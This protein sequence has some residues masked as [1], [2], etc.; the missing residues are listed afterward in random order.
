VSTNRVVG[1]AY[2]AGAVV[3]REHDR[4]LVISI[5]RR[6][7]DDLGSAKRPSGGAGRDE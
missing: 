5:V 7:I 2:D 6:F 3:A 1:E 4:L